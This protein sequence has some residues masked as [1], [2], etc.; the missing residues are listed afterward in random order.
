MYFSSGASDVKDK[1]CSIM[2]LF[3]ERRFRLDIR[4]KFFTERVV[5]YW[6]RL[7][8]EAVDDPSLEVFETRWD[9]ALGS[10]V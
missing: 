5:S 3:K 7:P 9:R 10:L 1:P 2:F 6:D 4:G 8:R